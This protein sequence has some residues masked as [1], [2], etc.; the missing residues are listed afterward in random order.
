MQTLQQSNHIWNE[1]IQQWNAKE[2]LKAMEGMQFALEVYQTAW[3]CF[4]S[5]SQSLELSR[6]AESGEHTEDDKL[7][8]NVE[9]DGD[10][11]FESSMV[12]AKRL[13]FLAYC[14]LD[15]GQVASARQRLVSHQGQVI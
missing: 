12:L 5:Q 6:S 7:D 4:G 8:W 1:A 11:F 13:L 15:G 2:Y 14:E 3:S 9:E 10:D